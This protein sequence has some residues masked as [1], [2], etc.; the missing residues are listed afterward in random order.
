MSGLNARVIT[1]GSYATNGSQSPP[2]VNWR[3]SAV[4]RGMASHG[5]ASPDAASAT[6][7]DAA[8]HALSAAYPALGKLTEQSRH[9]LL[10]CSRFRSARRREVICH[11]GDPSGAVILVIDGYLKRSMPLPDGNEALL[12]LVGPGECAGEMSA[13]REVPYDANLTAVSPCRLLIIEARQFR[14]SF[15]HEPAGLLAIMGSVDR[16]LQRTTDQL[17]DG[18]A[19][20]ISIRL[21]KTLLFLPRVPAPDSRNTTQLK[22]RLSQGELGAMAGICREAVNKQL[23]VWR[24]LGWIGVSAGTVTSIDLAALSVLLRDEAVED[25]GALADSG[26]PDTAWFRQRVRIA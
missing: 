3:H 7:I 4:S 15:E 25:R 16:Q 13:L 12:G 22:L 24:D 23:G 6:H 26:A 18:R 17:L 20:N 21:A 14:L 10:R 9:A 2:V 5:T 19:L 8:A 1:H 11:E